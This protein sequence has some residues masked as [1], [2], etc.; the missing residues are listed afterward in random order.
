MSDLN[1]YVMPFQQLGFGKNGFGVDYGRFNAT[2]DEED[3]YKFRTPP[4]INVTKTAP[5]S[6]SGAYPTLN[7]IIEAH[8]DPLAEFDGKNQ[9][10]IQRREFIA[11]LTKWRETLDE[12]HKMF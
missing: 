1:F 11:K 10:A 4:L 6:H 12:L 9:T 7:K 2:L 3:T 5:Y 8:V